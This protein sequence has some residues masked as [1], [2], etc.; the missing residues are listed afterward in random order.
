MAK[1]D[2]YNTIN[3][4]KIVEIVKNTDYDFIVKDIKNILDKNNENIA[5]STIYRILNE[6]LN[7]KIVLKV[8]TKS[9]E[10]H[11][12][13]IKRCGSSNCLLLKC[14]KCGEIFHVSCEII[15]KLNEHIEKQHKFFMDINNNIITGI[16]EN[17]RKE[18][19]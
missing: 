17:C 5:V 16:C 19:I 13:Y 8:L 7:D 14:T 9:K 2:R 6:L 3:K 1:R 4:E 18:E 15:S 12:R 10:T 11:Y